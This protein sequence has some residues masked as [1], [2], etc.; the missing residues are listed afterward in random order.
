M[1]DF[2]LNPAPEP[3]PHACGRC[4]NPWTGGRE[5]CPNNRRGA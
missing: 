3:Q 1:I 2:V 4:R 5:D